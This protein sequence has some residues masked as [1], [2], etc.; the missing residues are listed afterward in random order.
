[1]DWKST[2]LII[3]FCVKTLKKNHCFYKKNGSCF[4]FNNFILAF[5]R[6][7]SRVVSWKRLWEFF[8]E[9]Q[10]KIIAN[11][12]RR[13][14]MVESISHFFVAIEVAVDW[15]NY[16]TANFMTIRCDI[17]LS[18]LTIKNVQVWIVILT[19]LVKATEVE[20][21]IGRRCKI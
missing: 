2:F 7:I 20:K 19:V 14:I 5:N 13:E 12:Q 11:V 18:L 1:M 3:S 21:K 16:F 9:L 15:W 4:W 10:S 8:V 17:P 6:I